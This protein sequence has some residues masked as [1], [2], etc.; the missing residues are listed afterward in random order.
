VGTGGFGANW[1]RD[2]LPAAVHDNLIE[3]VAAVD[4]D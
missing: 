2:F 3:I 4:I 1:C